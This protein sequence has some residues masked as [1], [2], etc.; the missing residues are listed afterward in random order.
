[1]FSFSEEVVL[2]ENQVLHT[3]SSQW[4]EILQLTDMLWALAQNKPFR[5]KTILSLVTTIINNVE[6]TIH[7]SQSEGFLRKERWHYL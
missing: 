2:E 3:N 7:G 1:M 5:K 6:E 4:R